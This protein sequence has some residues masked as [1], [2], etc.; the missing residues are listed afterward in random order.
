MSYVIQIW[1]NPQSQSL[2]TSLVQAEQQLQAL[3]EQPVGTALPLFI[4]LAQ[5]LTERYPDQASAPI[6]EETDD[7]DFDSVAWTDSPMNGKTRT[8]VWNIGLNSAMLDEVRPFVI[9]Q[10]NALGLNVMDEQADEVHLAGGQVLASS[11]GAYCVKGFAAYYQGDFATA[12]QEFKQFAQQGNSV[13]QYNLGL[14]FSNG[15]GVKQ[16]YLIAY[17]LLYLSAIKNPHH[18]DTVDEIS[19]QLP[20]WIIEQGTVLANEMGQAGNLVNVLEQAIQK[21]QETFQLGE[22]AAKNGDYEQTLTLLMPVAEQGHEAAQFII[23]MMYDDGRGVAQDKKEAVKWYVRSAKNGFAFAQHNVALMYEQ[24]Q[25]VEKNLKKAAAWHT[26]A[27]KQ[28]FE[29]SRLALQRLQK[30]TAEIPRT[31][32]QTVLA[33]QA[34]DADAQYELAEIYRFGKGVEV[35]I[36]SSLSWLKLAANQGLADAQYN[37]G[38]MYSQGEGGPKNHLQALNCYR[39]AASQ[40]HALAQYNLGCM[41][42]SGQAVAQDRIAA[43]ALFLLSKKNGNTMKVDLTVQ[44][45]ELAQVN[46]LLSELIKPG[47]LLNALDQQQQQVLQEKIALGTAMWQ[48]HTASRSAERTRKPRQSSPFFKIAYAAMLIVIFLFGQSALKA[49]DS[50]Q[51]HYDENVCAGAPLTTVE[52]KDAAME[53]GYD[54]NQAYQCIDKQSFETVNAQKRSWEEHHAQTLAAERQQLAEEGATE[55][56][57]ARHEFKTAINVKDPQPLPLPNPPADLFVRND[58]KTPRKPWLPGFISPAPK[59]GR[60]HPAIIWLTGGD[61]NSL[62]D[63]WIQGPESNDQSAHAFRD[64]G[65]IMFFPTLRGGNGDDSG[66]EFFLGEVDDVLAAADQLNKLDY[67]DPEQIYLGGHS[68]GGTLALLTAAMKPRFKAIFSFG[69]VASVDS[70]PLS[71]IP[72]SFSDFDPMELK[73]RSPIHWLSGIDK[74]T[75]IIEGTDGTNNSA[76]LETLCATTSNPILHCI[77]VP[78]ANHFSVLNIATQRI[79]AKIISDTAWDSSFTAEVLSQ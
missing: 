5:R 43:L 57:Q 67:V 14:L 16:D 62:S 17:A 76:A 48:A 15:H 11:D 28:G 18:Q 26:R 75:Y 31:L 23:G 10:A 68:T 27:A 1:Q 25:F 79:A 20:S 77:R 7:V 41:Y 56:V 46:A 54:I 47:N 52:A 38:V 24:G 40:G 74:P 29:K 60:R 58:Y 35:D 2:P 12:L 69:P 70:Y 73:L 13:A 3:H 21:R 61:T 4:Q 71:L 55:L 53:A 51:K 63:F 65:I 39:L 37:L 32:E 6:D 22:N 36:Q 19:K 66:K 64:A 42:K 50:S 72:V 34:G 30:T 78:G 45:G 49:P 33:A 59:D 9:V 8:A 44:E